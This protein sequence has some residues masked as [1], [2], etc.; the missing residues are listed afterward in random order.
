[1]YNAQPPHRRLFVDRHPGSDRLH[2]PHAGRTLTFRDR[3]ALGYYDDP[4]LTE[5]A[6][7]RMLQLL[8]GAN[9]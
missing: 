2:A 8:N 9:N 1:M 5:A 3:V 6:V 4:H 7:V